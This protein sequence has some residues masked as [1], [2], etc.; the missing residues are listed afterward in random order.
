MFTAADKTGL[1]E[2]WQ[3]SID[4][5]LH[6]HSFFTYITFV[7]RTMKLLHFRTKAE[8]ETLLHLAVALHA[9][10]KTKDVGA[11]LKADSNI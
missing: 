8:T 1:L 11:M 4:T 9:K 10:H 3:P 2:G 6:V 5:G 7:K